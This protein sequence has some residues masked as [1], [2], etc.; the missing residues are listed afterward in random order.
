MRLEVRGLV[1]AERGVVAEGE[2]GEGCREKNVRQ[3]LFKVPGGYGYSLCWSEWVLRDDRKDGVLV[4]GC[5]GQAREGR[6]VGE[7]WGPP[8]QTHTS[9]PTR[10]C[11]SVWQPGHP[12]SSYSTYSHAISKSPIGV[13]H[14]AP[15]RHAIRDF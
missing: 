2:V 3:Y 13:A 4:V 1:E 9:H 12:R 7:G 5:W 14:F 8:R 10:R 11:L 6:L 15:R